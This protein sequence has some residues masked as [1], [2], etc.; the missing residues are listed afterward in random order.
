VLEIECGNGFRADPLGDR[1]H[2]GIHQP[3]LEGTV[4]P[5]QLVGAG[6]IGADLGRDG[7]R[8]LGQVAQ[9]GPGNRLPSRVAAR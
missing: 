9:V 2:D 1:Q 7:E 4:L 8:P 5:L 6:Q 3:Q